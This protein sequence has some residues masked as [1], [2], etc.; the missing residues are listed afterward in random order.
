MKNSNKFEVPIVVIGIILYLILMVGQGKIQAMG[1]SFLNGLVAQLQ[2]ILIVVMTVKAHKKGFIASVIISAVSSIQTLLMI[3]LVHHQ[4]S[5]LP[6]VVVP[7]VTILMAYLIY[8][9]ASKMTK[10]NEELSVAIDDLHKANDVLVAKDKKLMYLAY[11]DVLTGLPNKQL[12]VDTIDKKI[13]ENEKSPFT[14]IEANIDNIREIN[15]S[16]GL[17]VADEIIFSY[18]EKIK[19]VCSDK[20]FVARLSNSRFIILVDSIQ[21]KS[22]INSITNTINAVLNEPVIVKNIAF[23]TTMSY[24]IVTYPNNAYSTERLIQYANITTDQVIANGGNSI[25]FCDD[26]QS[27]YIKK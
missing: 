13:A 25:I 9:Y 7:L 4:M 14:L 19:K 3:V 12:L 5:A 22:D 21:T 11:H 24:G 2:T 23:K 18:S 10:A 26:C 1:L 17:N 15:Y 20:Y 27:M 8:S 6:G 16:Y